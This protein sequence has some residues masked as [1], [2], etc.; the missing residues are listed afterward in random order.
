MYAQ[1]GPGRGENGRGRGRKRKRV[2][3]GIERGVRN[4]TV[5][6]SSTGFLGITVVIA[7]LGRDNGGT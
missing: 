4:S 3:K 1:L 7:G 5:S 2:K 6:A